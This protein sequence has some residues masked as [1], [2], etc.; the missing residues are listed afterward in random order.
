MHRRNYSRPLFSALFSSG[1]GFCNKSCCNSQGETAVLNSAS[2]KTWFSAQLF[3]YFLG[4][5][6]SSLQKE[7]QKSANLIKSL[8]EAF[9]EILHANG[10]KIKFFT[11]IPYSFTLHLELINYAS[12]AFE[13]RIQAQTLDNKNGILGKRHLISIQKLEKKILYIFYV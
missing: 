5:A 11:K 4:E 2:Y 3:C 10:S 8:T 9:T 1:C 12:P 13:I 7:L 6:E